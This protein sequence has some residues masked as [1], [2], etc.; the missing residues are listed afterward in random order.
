M[1]HLQWKLQTARPQWDRLLGQIPALDL[2]RSAQRWRLMLGA[3]LQASLGTRAA[4]LALRRSTKES[5]RPHSD[6][7][8]QGVRRRSSLACV[9]VP[10]S[11]AVYVHQDN[12]LELWVNTGEMPHCDSDIQQLQEKVRACSTCRSASRSSLSLLG[13]CGAPV[14][15]L[16]IVFP[17]CCCAE[18]L[19]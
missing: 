14:R 12:Q 10:Y 19:W 1:A 16:C 17:D 6:L 18:A 5:R 3:A 7:D 2:W 9:T 15:L 13:L 8:L 11:S 4:C